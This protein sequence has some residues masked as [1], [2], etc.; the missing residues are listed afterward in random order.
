MTVGAIYAAVALGVPVIIAAPVAILVGTAAGILL[1]RLAIKPAGKAPLVSLVIITIGSSIFLRGV[2]QFIFDKQIH[3][4][5]GFSGGDRPALSGSND[6]ATEPVDHPRQ[7]R[8]LCGT[9]LVHRPHPC[10]P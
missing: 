8:G 5:E 6:P 7:L 1:Y 4:Y 2:M 9:C 3:R 10:G